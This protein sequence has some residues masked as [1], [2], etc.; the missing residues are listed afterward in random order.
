MVQ[1]GMC[2]LNDGDIRGFY[3]EPE[4]ARTYTVVSGDTLSGIGVKTGTNWQDIAR[5]NGIAAPYVIYPGQVLQ[6]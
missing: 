2:W 5:K 4:V 6:L 1:F 3:S